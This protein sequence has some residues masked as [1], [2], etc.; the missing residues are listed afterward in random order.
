MKAHKLA[1]KPTMPHYVASILNKPFVFFSTMKENAGR[2]IIV[3]NSK[4][5]FT[6]GKLRG[7][8]KLFDKVLL[9]KHRKT[10]YNGR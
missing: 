9:G 7:F 1:Q 5:I 6:N 2:K 3:P 10:I 8:I 4:A